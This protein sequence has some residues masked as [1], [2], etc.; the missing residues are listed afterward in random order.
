MTNLENTELELM[1]NQET[2]N[3]DLPDLPE[4]GVEQP[5]KLDLKNG[6]LLGLAV[7]GGIA[8]VSGGGILVK[9]GLD[10]IKKWKADRAA[11]KAEKADKDQKKDENPDPAPEPEAKEENPKKEKEKK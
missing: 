5:E 2:M 3:S 11:K 4:D 10:K 6:A 8:I 7:A 1:E 9:K